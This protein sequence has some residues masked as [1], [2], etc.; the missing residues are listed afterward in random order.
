MRLVLLFSS[1]YHSTLF[2]FANGYLFYLFLLLKI[3]LFN[4]VHCDG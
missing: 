2:F 1:I 4:T 3:T